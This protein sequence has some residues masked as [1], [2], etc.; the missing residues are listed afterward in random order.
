MARR[1]LTIALVVTGAIADEIDGLRR[2]LGA[3]ALERIAP[4]CTLVPPVNVREE[5]LAEVLGQVRSAAADNAPISVSLGPPKTFWPRTPVLYLSVDGDLRPVAALA[6]KLSNGPLAPPASR[7]EREFVPHV[8]LDQRID[9]G[10]LAHA[11]AAL[12]DYRRPYR[13]ERLTVLE[14][15]AGHRWRPLA[16]APLGK[17]AVAGRGSLDLELTVF[18]SPDP[19]VA[20]WADEQWERY[21]S[22]RDGGVVGPIEPYAIVARSDDRPIGFADGE[23]RGQVCRLGRLIV[24]PEWRSRGVGSHVMRAVERLGL[25]RGCDR[26]RLET[27]AGASAEQFFAERGFIVTATL[28]RWC[29][30][31]DFVLMERDIAVVPQASAAGPRRLSPHAGE[32]PDPPENSRPTSSTR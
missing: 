3:K 15:D 23:I 24:S 17:P 26:V 21:S 18:E 30:G 9:P 2:A 25:E 20:A 22:E 16:D 1:R 8:T 27:V 7:H 31:R 32:S 13:F 29:E 19:F 5:S 12:A 10:R 14:Q 28:P 11:L 6:D 4:H